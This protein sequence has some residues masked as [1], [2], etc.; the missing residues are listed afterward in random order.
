M[1]DNGP[2]G[3]VDDCDVGSYCWNV[4]AATNEGVCVTPCMGSQ[5]NP[6]CEDASLSCFQLLGTPVIACVPSCDPLA[7]ACPAAMTCAMS[8]SSGYAPLCISQSLG[9][10]TGAGTDCSFQ[11]GCGDGFACVAA[12]LVGNCASGSCCASI[13]DLAAPSCPA[14]HPSCTQVPTTPDGIGACALAM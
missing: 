11:L 3:G 9:V 7:P 2:W 4:D 12:E 6:V 8:L 13:C 5:A 14:D 1:A 10:P